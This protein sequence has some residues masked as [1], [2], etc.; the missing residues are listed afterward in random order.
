MDR[1]FSIVKRRAGIIKQEARNTHETELEAA[2]ETTA[3]QRQRLEA[4]NKELRE[5][6]SK[7]TRLQ[8]EY[9]TAISSLEEAVKVAQDENEAVQEE[10][11]GTSNLRAELSTTKAKNEALRKH[12]ETAQRSARAI[13]EELRG[14]KAEA[15]EGNKRVRRLKAQLLQVYRLIN[16]EKEKSRRETELEATQAVVAQAK[17]DTSRTQDLRDFMRRE[18]EIRADISRVED[19]IIQTGVEI[20]KCSSRKVPFQSAR[21]S[22]RKGVD[23]VA[24]EDLENMLT[25]LHNQAVYYFAD[26]TFTLVELMRFQ[27]YLANPKQL[28]DDGEF[29]YYDPNYTQKRRRGLDR[30]VKD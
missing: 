14:L 13:E 6:R 26:S 15:N 27:D 17:A 3:T 7:V 23:Y 9:Q 19:S 25:K 29:L 28:A 4:L 5:A 21:T 2:R 30:D 16:L 20:L 1:M 11:E 18:A 24:I 8:E 12:P 10:A 22:Y